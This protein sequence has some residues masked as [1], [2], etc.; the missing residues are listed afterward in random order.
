M[1]DNGFTEITKDFLRRQRERLFKPKIKGVTNCNT[2]KL[3]QKSI[4][5]YLYPGTS[6]KD[7]YRYSLP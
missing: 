2:H 1:S 4:D 3:K 5:D 6:L 7:G